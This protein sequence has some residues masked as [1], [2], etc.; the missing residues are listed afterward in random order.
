MSV[1]LEHWHCCRDLGTAATWSLRR[2]DALAGEIRTALNMTERVDSGRDRAGEP[3]RGQ[4][5]QAGP[6]RP[7]STVQE[8]PQRE[9]QYRPVPTG[10]HAD[11]TTISQPAKMLEGQQ[12][13]QAHSQSHDAAAPPSE[14]TVPGIDKASNDAPPRL[15]GPL[16]PF[17]I[18]S[19]E[20]VNKVLYEQHGFKRTDR[21]GQPS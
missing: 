5:W 13:S 21:H 16:R 20:A 3:S 2:L 14:C 4:T 19:L 7:G 12:A 10:P 6:Q 9:E 18:H 8:P 17:D 1:Y 15:S 11:N